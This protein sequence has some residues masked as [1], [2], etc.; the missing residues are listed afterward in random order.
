MHPDVDDVVAVGVENEVA[1]QDVLVAVCAKP[2]RQVE[3][4]A[5]I[6]FLVPRLAY[7]MVPR[8]VRIVAELPRTETNKVREVVFREQG[9]TADTWD[10]ERAGLPAPPE[11][12]LLSGPPGTR[13]RVAMPSIEQVRQLE[14]QLTMVVPAN[15]EDHNGH[16]NVQHYLTVYDESGWPLFA[17]FGLDVARLADEGAS[18]FDL[19]HHTW[20]LAELHV[21]DTISAHTRMLARGTKR[22]HGVT[23]IVNDSRAR[24]AAAL[25][26]VQHGGRPAH[27]PHARVPTDVASRLQAM[28]DRHAALAWSAPRCGSMSA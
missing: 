3:P 14:A 2:G 5:L 18:F 15:W 6:E 16:V 11:A 9:V 7:F 13:M 22:V 28:I 26:F 19:E 24:L 1:E 20:F 8:Y 10:R 21:G 17:S 12:T 4:R 25:E 23:F 27:S